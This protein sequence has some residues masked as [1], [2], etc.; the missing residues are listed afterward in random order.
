MIDIIQNI[1]EKRKDNI[2]KSFSH[3]YIRKEGNRYIYKESKEDKKEVNIMAGDVLT[4]TL[5]DKVDKA[6][7]QYGGF[8][9]IGGKQKT[10][11]FHPEIRTVVGIKK[12]HIKGNVD[13]FLENFKKTMNASIYD[14]KII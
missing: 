10:S 12:E 2:L 5:L 4:K 3:K 13:K 7:Y 14:I 11:A 8:K 9:T 6:A 1:N